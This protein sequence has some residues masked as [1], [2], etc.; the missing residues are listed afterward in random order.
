MLEAGGMTRITRVRVLLVPRSS[1]AVKVAWKEPALAYW[2]AVENPV[3]LG[4]ASP[5]VQ[6][7]AAM[8]VPA[9]APWVAAPSKITVLPTSTVVS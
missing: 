7:A 2:W 6:D 9:E 8:A 1:L 5:K 4:L 3:L